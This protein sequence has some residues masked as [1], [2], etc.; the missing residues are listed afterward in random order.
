[1]DRAPFYMDL[2]SIALNDK[3]YELANKYLEKIKKSGTEINYNLLFVESQIL[4]EMGKIQEALKILE[5]ARVSNESDRNT[6]SHW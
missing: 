4:T 6:L 2:I 5:T 3:E 1:M